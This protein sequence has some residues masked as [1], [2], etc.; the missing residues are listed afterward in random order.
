MKTNVMRILCVPAFL[1]AIVAVNGLNAQ[2]QDESASAG[3][4]TFVVFEGASNKP[5]N[6]KHIVLVS[7][8]EEYR[9]EEMLTQ[10]ARILSKHHGFRCTVLYAIDPKDGTINPVVIDNIPG[11]ETL[12]KADLMVMFLRFRNLPDDQ[13]QH[14]VDYL[15]AGRPLLGI[16]TS[17][18]AFNIPGDRKWARYSFNFNENLTSNI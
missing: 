13:M 15:K 1:L 3:K 11:L 12:E 2:S 16:R 9:S 8:D 7:G 18:H 6:G 4:K 5:G 17:T 14:I 10:L